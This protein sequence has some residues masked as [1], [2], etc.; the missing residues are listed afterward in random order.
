MPLFWRTCGRIAKRT[1]VALIATALAGAH[2]TTIN[3]EYQLKAVFL[4]NFLQ[5][6]DWPTDAFEDAHSPFHVC[7]LG[8]D[9]FGHDLDEVMSGE[10]LENRPILVERHADVADTTHC[11]LVFIAEDSATRRQRSLA[12]LQSKPILTVGDADDFAAR[13]GI[14]E[15][16]VANNRIKLLVNLQAASDAQLRLSS[17]LLRKSQIVASRGS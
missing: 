6:V 7:I 8:G 10:Q 14:I 17:K 3:Q 5:F 9:P 15:L 4:F 11:H 13:G 12:A 2:A 1:L 16:D